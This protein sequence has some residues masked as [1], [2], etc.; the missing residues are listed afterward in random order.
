MT[1]Q[2]P[3]VVIESRVQLYSA[4]SEAAELEHNFHCLYLYAVCSLKRTIDE[5]V[6][7]KQIAA[8]ELGDR[9]F[10]A[11]NEVE[12]ERLSHRGDSVSTNGEVPN[13]LTRLR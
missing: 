7:P 6:T 11:G 10:T 5:G 12:H 1:D 9:S 3:H 2:S 13:S 4:L 8:I